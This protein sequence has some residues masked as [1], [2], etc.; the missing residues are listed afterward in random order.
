[1]AAV[2][3]AS[4]IMT[5]SAINTAVE[6]R[7]L[8]R[9]E[10]WRTQARTAVLL[11]RHLPAGCFFT[12][13]D[14]MPRSAWSGHMAKLRGARSRVPDFIFI[15]N[16]ETIWIEMKSH[17]GIASRVQRQIRDELLAAGVKFWFLVRSPRAWGTASTLE[18]WEGPFENPYARL[19]Q[20]PLVARV[21][22]EARQ[23]CRLRKEMRSARPCSW[24][25]KA[26]MTMRVTPA[27]PHEGGDD[28]DRH[29]IP[30][31]GP[32]EIFPW[33][34][35]WKF[36]F[37]DFLK[38]G[39]GGDFDLA[40]KVP[41]TVPAEGGRGGAPIRR[42][43]RACLCGGRASLRRNH[44]MLSGLAAAGASAA[45]YW[46]SVIAAAIRGERAFMVE[47]GRY[48]HRRAAAQ[49]SRADRARLQGQA[50]RNCAPSRFKSLRKVIG[51]R[52]NRPAEVA[53]D[54]QR[55]DGQLEVHRSI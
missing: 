14:N 25:R 9:R 39:P 12:A 48:K 43:T 29:P 7:R 5:D 53:E 19:A 27:S 28:V 1:M 8:L 36:S 15:W 18:R 11:K 51:D 35:I 41:G 55:L 49:G 23:R 13:L 40:A 42:T 24:R 6:R 20:H 26:A 46:R 31:A 33:K 21:R 44:S 38:I 34:K 50:A 47:L 30:A 17:V 10:E 4:I 37:L 32:G 2:T 45:D 22:A 16:G 54:W 52:P 3:A